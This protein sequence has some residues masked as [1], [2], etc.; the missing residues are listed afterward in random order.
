[1]GSIPIALPVEILDSKGAVTLS[2]LS[3]FDSVGVY[4]LSPSLSGKTCVLV[5]A[6]LGGYA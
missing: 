6:Y 1:M 4:I 3:S 2:F 5:R